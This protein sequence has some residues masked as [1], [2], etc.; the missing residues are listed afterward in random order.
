METIKNYLESMFKALPQTEKVLKAK[1]ELLQMM[2]DKYTELINNGKSDNEAI[3]TVI[4]E[5]GN[6]DELAEDLGIK[7]EN[8][9]LKVIN[10]EPKEEKGKTAP[11][12]K[13]YV[14]NFI[15]WR[16]KVGL[17]RGIGIALCILSVISPIIFSTFEAIEVFGGVGLFVIVAI[18]VLLIVF[19]NYSKDDFL[20]IKTVRCSIDEDTYSYVKNET[21]EYN[22]TYS[23]YSA[24]AIAF[25][26]LSVVPPILFDKFNSEF[27]DNIGASLLFVFV[28]FGVFLLVYANIK[29]NA[30]IFILNSTDRK[31]ETIN[32]SDEEKFENMSN[33]KKVYYDPSTWN[34]DEDAQEIASIKN[35]KVRKILSVYWPTVTCAYLLWSFVT[36]DWHI[37]WI[38]WPI[39]GVVYS[40]IKALSDKE[41]KD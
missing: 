21:R 20:T 15:S 24:I 19:S 35:P 30:L 32:K 26:I 37:S 16:S 36:F 13:E 39:A 14:E 3:G 33:E 23:I 11:I 29:K 9:A 28:A 17:Y 31:K 2:E 1:Q 40:L 4:S 22:K 7:N 10:Q 34:K 5:F 27:A 41:I 18:G 6:L 25:F 12:T 38:I 8:D